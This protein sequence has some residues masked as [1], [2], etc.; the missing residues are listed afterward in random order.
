MKII[1]IWH[2]VSMVI[3]NCKMKHC[4]KHCEIHHYVMMRKRNNKLSHLEGAKL[5]KFLSINKLSILVLENCKKY[6]LIQYK[7]YKIPSKWANGYI[8]SLIVFKQSI[9]LTILQ[10]KEY[11]VPRISEKLVNI[12]IWKKYQYSLP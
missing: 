3:E 9:F 1:L 10:K 8:R 2:K 6:H 7:K 11:F 4:I 12:K 5:V